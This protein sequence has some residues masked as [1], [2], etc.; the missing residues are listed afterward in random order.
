MRY[1]LRRSLVLLCIW[2]FSVSVIA[3]S[4]LI[5]AHIFSNLGPEW[6]IRGLCIGLGMFTMSRLMDIYT[7]KYK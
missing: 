7:R 1:R 5:V 2:I 4:E 3:F 6:L